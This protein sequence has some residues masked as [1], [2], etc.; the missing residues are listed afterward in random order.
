MSDRRLAAVLR[1]YP[2]GYRADRGAELAEVYDSLAA[3]TG[4][5]GRARELAGLAGHGLRLRVGL[6]SGGLPGLLIAAAVPF[7]VGAG[8][9]RQAGVMWQMS[10]YHFAWHGPLRWWG[11]GLVAVWAMALAVGLAGRWA[12]ARWIAVAATIGGIALEVAWSVQIPPFQH[13]PL[14]FYLGQAV[15]ACVGLAAWLVLLLPAPVDLL[16]GRVR[17]AAPVALAGVTVAL[18]L[19]MGK[20]VIDTPLLWNPSWH[21]YRLALVALPLL[22]LARG[23]VLPAAAAIGALPLLLNDDL[24][25]WIDFELGGVRRAAGYLALVVLAVVWARWLRRRHET[26]L[27]HRPPT[28]D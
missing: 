24:W 27:S 25:F 22:G 1:L 10:P 18:L 17:R 3:G 2:R 28:A 26:G 16:G 23:R 6:T 11:V 4:R 20:E 13:L 15:R 8:L 9:G 7:V 19:T 14:S 12:A 21:P 5:L